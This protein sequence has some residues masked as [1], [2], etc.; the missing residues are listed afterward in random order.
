M[1]Y[2]SSAE[3]LTVV[4]AKA[5]N[6]KTVEELKNNTASMWIKFYFM[7]NF[8]LLNFLIVVVPVKRLEIHDSL[9]IMHKSLQEELSLPT[10]PP[11]LSP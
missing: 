9:H 3:R 11:H 6:L 8:T 1:T 4:V 2:L 7:I 10:P 5:R